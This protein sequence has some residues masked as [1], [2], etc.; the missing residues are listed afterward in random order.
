[1]TSAAPEARERLQPVAL[2]GRVDEPLALSPNLF[3]APHF[4]AW[5]RLRQLWF[6]LRHRFASCQPVVGDQLEDLT[7]LAPRLDEAQITEGLAILVRVFRPYPMEYHLGKRPRAVAFPTLALLRVGQISET[8][9]F[10]LPILY[11]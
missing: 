7:I 11:G 3:L 9:G 8:R 1:M 10:L 2:R 6:E 4:T 5:H